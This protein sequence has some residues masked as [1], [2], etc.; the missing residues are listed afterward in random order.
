MHCRLQHGVKK[1]DDR[2]F[3]DNPA[4]Q[5]SNTFPTVAKSKRCKDRLYQ[6]GPLSQIAVLHASARKVGKPP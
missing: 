5:R 6:L 2:L 3:G 4:G 1:A